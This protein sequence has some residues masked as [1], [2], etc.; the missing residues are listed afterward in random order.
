ML[1]AVLLAAAFALLALAGMGSAAAQES[2]TTTAGATGGAAIIGTLT[3]DGNPV[4]NVKVT[5]SK[6]GSEVGS[7]TSDAQGQWRIPVPGTGT[8][9]LALDTATLPEGVRAERAEL[10]SFRVLGNNAQRVLFRLSSG[11][12]KA[13][14][15]GPSRFDRF[16]NLFVSGIRF[17]L[18]VGLCSV[19][20]SLIYGTTGLVNFAH[21]ELV[22]FG[23][24]VA[25]FFNTMSSGPKVPLLL[26]AILGMIG[27]GLLAGATELGIWRPMTRLRTGA[28]ARMLVSIGL[29]LFLRYLYQVIFTGNPRAYRQYSA[30]SP[31]EFGPLSN[32]PRDY[33][34]MVIS[35]IVLVLVGVM[36]QRTRLGTAVRAV[37]DERDLASASGI[38]V[39]RVVL[40]VWVGGAALAGLG[41]VLL[42][43]SQSAQ[44]NLGFRLLLTMF[45]AVVLG[46]LGSPYGAMAGGLVV[47]VAS[48]VSTYWPPA[49]FQFAIALVILI[50]VLL[51][52]PQGLLGVRERVG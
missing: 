45:A 40:L 18:I 37:A 8:Y 35:A 24:L 12:T 19:G 10:P 51:V 48:Q 7:A 34:V 27:A 28:V 11:E 49:D 26:A 16:A 21:G 47:G 39:G 5:A 15:S 20:L 13:A 22:T 3:V 30:Q 25:F 14:P 42:A 6:S 9:Q 41:G 17:G 36:L 50:L 43:V 1:V 4:P 52:R 31:I 23:A 33:I 38:D 32:P 29:A 46:G 2:T 44:W